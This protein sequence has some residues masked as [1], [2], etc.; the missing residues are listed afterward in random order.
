MRK[1]YRRIERLT[2]NVAVLRATG[3]GFEELALVEG[4]GGRSLAQV[5]RL[6]GDEVSLQV[7]GGTRGVG[8]PSSPNG[9]KARSIFII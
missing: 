1:Y 5:I 3:V 8:F 7:F 4:R 2:G 6:D 9:R